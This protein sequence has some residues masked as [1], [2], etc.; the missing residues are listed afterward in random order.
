MNTVS[1]TVITG[2]TST[3]PL[4]NI[5]IKAGVN[6]TFSGGGTIKGLIYI[7]T[8]NKVTFSGGTNMTGVI[9]VDNPNEATP[10]NAIIFSGGGVMQGPENLDSSYGTLRTMT[11]ALILRPILPSPSPAA[12]RIRRERSRQV[13]LPL[14]RLG[15]IG[16]WQRHHLRHRQHHLLRWQR[17]HLHQCRPGQHPH[18]R[19]PLLRIF[20]SRPRLVPEPGP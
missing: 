10:T 6:P 5:R 9:V 7:E 20:P 4:S 15:W 8:P 13:R 14:R 3:T 18:R 11:G 17:L 16:Q 1:M 19:C 12:R 2:S